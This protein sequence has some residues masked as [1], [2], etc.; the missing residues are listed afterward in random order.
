MNIKNFYALHDVSIKIE[1]QKITGITGTSGSGKTTL[2]DILSGLLELQQGK[3]LIDESE[4]GSNQL[5]IL[6]SAIG[7]VPQETYLMDDSI[8]NNIVLD[9]NIN[10]NHR[11]I[12]SICEKLNLNDFIRNLPHRYE[13]NVG[14]M[15]QDSAVQQRLGIVRALY[16]DLTYLMNPLAI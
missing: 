4:L 9:Q 11:K 8:T 7:Y 10:I 2:M 15:H 12:E 16:R 13:Y 1:K 14:E 3:I 6:Q 5:T